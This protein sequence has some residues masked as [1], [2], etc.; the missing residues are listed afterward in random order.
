MQQ[1]GVSFGQDGKLEF[2]RSKLTQA[3]SLDEEGVKNFLTKET[4]GFSAR[5]KVVLDGLVG[6]NGSALVN[7]TKSIQQKIDLNDRRI[8]SMNV[9]LAREK[10]RLEKQFFDL[11]NTIAKIRNNS[12][13]LGSITSLFANSNA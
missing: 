2:D 3:I 7:S 5:A 4:T 12:T 11:E 6:I 13:S 1:L 9:R 10:E 8:A